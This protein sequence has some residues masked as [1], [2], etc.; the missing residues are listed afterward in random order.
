MKKAELLKSRIVH[1]EDLET[2]SST[3]KKSLEMLVNITGPTD[4]KHADTV[5]R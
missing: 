2:F 1:W 5:Y 4:G 3:E